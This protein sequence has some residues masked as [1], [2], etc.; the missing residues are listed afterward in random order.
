MGSA[1][2]LGGLVQDRLHHP[3]EIIGD[4]AVPEAQDCPSAVRQEHRSAFI[5][6]FGIQ[7]LGAIEFYG[8]LR[9]TACEVNDIWADHQ[10]A[11]EAGAI[12]GYSVP[13]LSLRLGLA[14]A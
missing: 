10:L 1:E 14:V 11:C 5:I 6:S 3:V 9:R 12:A 8:E 13:N 4:V 2:A 7:M